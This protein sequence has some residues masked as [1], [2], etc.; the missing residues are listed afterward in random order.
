VVHFADVVDL[1]FTAELE[2]RLDEIARGQ[3]P[4][5][6]VVSAY[7]QPLARHVRDAN[8][9]AVPASGGEPSDEVCSQGHP[10][11]IRDGRFGRFLACS[12][13]PDHQESRPLLTPLGVA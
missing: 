13:Y 3:R 4:W 10:M 6:P 1:A 2:V 8:A 5:I 12:G 9:G 11:V 7:Y